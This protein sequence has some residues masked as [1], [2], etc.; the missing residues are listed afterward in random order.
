M[1][2]LDTTTATT[3]SSNRNTPNPNLGPRTSETGTVQRNKSFA[4]PINVRAVPKNSHDSISIVQERF[5]NNLYTK[6]R[7]SA[8]EDVDAASTEH[9]CVMSLLQVTSQIT[10]FLCCSMEKRHTDVAFRANKTY[11]TMR[12]EHVNRVSRVYQESNISV[13]VGPL[14][15]TMT[16]THGSSP[17]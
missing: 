9:D 6:E 10:K 4:K 3:K 8:T 2:N 11:P 1:A 17:V 5:L 12:E 15:Q 14:L 13:A 7:R 16:K